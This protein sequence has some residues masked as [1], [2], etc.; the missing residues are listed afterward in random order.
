[1][2]KDALKKLEITPEIYD[3]INKANYIRHTQIID[4]V[5]GLL[6]EDALTP[7]D[8]YE[9]SLMYPNFFSL[10]RNNLEE[11]LFISSFER[12]YLGYASEVQDFRNLHNFAA[13]MNLINSDKLIESSVNGDLISISDS[14]NLAKQDR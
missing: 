8:K 3:V 10:N 4:R 14:L 2:D 1:V 11:H 7:S 13:T 9:F 12:K 6:N 5:V